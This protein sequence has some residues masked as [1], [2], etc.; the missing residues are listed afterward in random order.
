[1]VVGADGGRTKP[2]SRADV[3]LFEQQKS[4][5]FCHLKF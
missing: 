5:D 4:F 3:Q 1:V 2:S